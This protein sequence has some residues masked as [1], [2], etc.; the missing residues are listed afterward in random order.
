MNNIISLGGANGII[1]FASQSEVNNA[2]LTRLWNLLVYKGVIDSTKTHGG[3]SDGVIKFDDEKK[4][5]ERFYK[6][7][8]R[9]FQPG[10]D[11]FERAAGTKTGS[12]QDRDNKLD[13]DEQRQ[14]FQNAQAKLGNYLGFKDG[15]GL[16]ILDPIYICKDSNKQA[17]QQF[18]QEVSQAKIID[19]PEKSD[20]ASLVNQVRQKLR[21]EFLTES[22]DILSPIDDGALSQKEYA[23]VQKHLLKKS[24]AQAQNTQTAISPNYAGAAD[25]LQNLDL[26]A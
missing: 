7:D 25:K 20:F 24:E 17:Q 13:L 19:N 10:I 15:K 26:V 4:Q 9:K 21:T 14:L 12:A 1:D 5:K 11:F 6:I 2:N 18:I 8:Y 23:L 3:S 22:K 16:E